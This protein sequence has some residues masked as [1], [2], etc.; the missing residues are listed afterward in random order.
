MFTYIIKRL[1]IM[2]PTFFV[3][4]CI[5]FVILNLAPGRPTPAIGDTEGGMNR[6]QLQGS[7]AVKEFN[8]RFHFDKPIF[9]NTRFALAKDK[10]FSA[11]EYLAAKS[12]KNSPLRKDPHYF[13][14]LT[15]AL[16]NLLDW[17]LDSVPHL[18]AIAT[19]TQ[20]E[21]IRYVAVTWLS[22]NAQ[23]PILRDNPLE[24]NHRIKVEN[25]QVSKMVYKRNASKA[26]IEKVV[27][28]WQKWYQ[29]KQSQLFSYSFVDKVRIFFTETRFGYYWSNLL[30]LNFGI[31]HITKK[32]VFPT[33]LEK[34]QYSVCISFLGI[35]FAYLIAVPIGVFS[36]V[37]RGSKID[38]V[39][40]VILFMLY[41]L[42]AFFTGPL[43]LKYFGGEGADWIYLFPTGNFHNLDPDIFNNWPPHRR[44]LDIAW[45]LILPV[46]MITYGALAALSRYARS[47]LLEVVNS[48]YIRTAR[49]KGLRERT[50]I[51]RHAVRNGMIP[52]L[53]MLGTLLPIAVSGSIVIEYIFNIPGIG[54]LMLDAITNR[55]YNTIMC[56]SLI[57][58]ALTLI[59]ILLS[60]IS[61]ALVDPRITYN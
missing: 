11:V 20:D 7:E 44:L 50:V 8:K 33:V 43:L 9:F 35:L 12:K 18:V 57:A 6:D 15:W 42:P 16:D 34:V 54:L 60:D 39:I 61:Y 32:E 30:Q 26:E 14:R 25:D 31:S 27:A 46:T 24:I 53:T 28:K 38:A 40:T 29:K 17:G 10:V 2:V 36:A 21:E 3:I 37:K 23:Q 58:S 22:I 56:I 59:G 48:D 49:A 47:G 19:E 41:A 1:L 4:S 45:H 55:D 52:I 5:V 13:K 51:L